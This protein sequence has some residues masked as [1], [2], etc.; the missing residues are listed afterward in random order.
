[1]FTNSKMDSSCSKS[2]SARTF[3][4]YHLPVLLY[5]AAILTVSSL[6]ELQ[7][8]EVKG[9]ELDKLAH[10][11]EYAIFAFLTFRSFCRWELRLV[12]RHAFLFS[13]LFLTL[14]AALD[15]IFQKFIPGRHSEVWDI[16]A[17]LLGALLV[18][19]LMELHRRKAARDPD[20]CS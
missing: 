3:L 20:P 14:F 12:S 11:L 4:V 5:A 18:L 16:L 10:L 8:P 7:T 1:M 9:V 15:E 13:A 19:V 6:T 17:D 2:G